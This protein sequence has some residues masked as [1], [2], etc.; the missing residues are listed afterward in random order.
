MDAPLDADSDSDED[1]FDN[2]NI[3]G[4]NFLKII[5]IYSKKQLV[6]TFSVGFK[7]SRATTATTVGECSTP[8]PDSFAEK[9]PEKLTSCSQLSTSDVIAIESP[10][11]PTS[12]TPRSEL[13]SAGSTKGLLTQ[14][15][16]SEGAT[17]A[18]KVVINTG[19]DEESTEQDG[20]LCET[21][22]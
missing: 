3:E 22:F 14:G 5:Y 17:P 9:S 7:L 8:D 16:S 4:C 2:P 13:S 20:M 12:V 10:S 19:D 21:Q 1:N 15:T 11:A 18:S 6:N